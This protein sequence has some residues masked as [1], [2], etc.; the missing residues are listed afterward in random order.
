MPETVRS[1][2]YACVIRSRQSPVSNHV[3]AYLSLDSD[4][5]E[6]GA[7]FPLVSMIVAID[8]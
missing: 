3:S 6:Q 4:P 2:I 8:E 1:E 7:R 5:L